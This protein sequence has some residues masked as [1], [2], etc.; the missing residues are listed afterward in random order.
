MA[1]KELAN[2]NWNP[3]KLTTFAILVVLAT[4]VI[5]GVVVAN[6]MGGPAAKTD[7]TASQNPLPGVPADQAAT[8]AQPPPVNAP[9]IPPP[10]AP[11]SYAANPPPPH[12][13]AYDAPARPSRAQVERCNQSAS[14][15]RSSRAGEALKDGLFGG[16]LG[17]GLGAAGGAIAGGGGG[18]GKG[19]GIGGL[20]GAAAGSLYGLNEANRS[21]ERAVAAYRAC[22]RR[23]GYVD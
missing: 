21:D 7:S 13:R 23:H 3:W 9:A 8:E 22:M 19:A 12:A 11:Q 20:V 16:A 4:A 14:S 17:A 15:A 5:T 18:A 6:Y 2:L 10:N 1:D